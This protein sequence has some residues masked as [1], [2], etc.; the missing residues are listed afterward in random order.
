MSNIELFQHDDWN[1]RVV[2]VDGEP[3][4]VVA[5]VCKSLSIANAR[6]AVARLAEDGVGTADIIDSLGRKQTANVVDESGLYELIFQSRRPE[7]KEFRRWVT[8]E[9]LPQ[10][11]KTGGYGNTPA[12]PQ[13]YGEALRELADKVDQIAILAPKAAAHDLLAEADGAIT[14]NAAAHRLNIGE[15]TLW[16]RC[17]DAGV[18][19]SNG[20][21]R[22]L[23]YRKYDHHFKVVTKVRS[24][25]D[26]K[27]R[28]YSQTLVRTSG[29]LFL[30][31]KLGLTLSPEQLAL[32]G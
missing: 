30:A 24:D 10:I 23:P 6:D 7:A 29:L 26:G 32:S 13:T 4:F 2:D 19:Q 17:R 3:W 15:V 21:E 25:R 1:V 31:N 27:D 22:N 18:F 28:Q 9:V 5:D 11:R 8:R 16:R 14:M 20:S 12:L